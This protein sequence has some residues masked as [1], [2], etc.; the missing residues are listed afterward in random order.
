MYPYRGMFSSIVRFNDNKAAYVQHCEQKHNYSIFLID[1][2][3][4][5]DWLL[6]TVLQS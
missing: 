2:V 4:Y 5:F 6:K 3:N 1:F